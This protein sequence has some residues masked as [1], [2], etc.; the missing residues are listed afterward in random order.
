MRQMKIMINLFLMKKTVEKRTLLGNKLNILFVS[1]ISLID[2]LCKER[3]EK[4]RF[5]MK[6]LD[7]KNNSSF[8]N[9]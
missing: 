2:F 8:L 1:F 7:Y 4:F 5:V 3:I 9:K 6:T